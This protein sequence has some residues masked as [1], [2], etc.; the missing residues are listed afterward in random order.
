MKG[1]NG[2]IGDWI[3]GLSVLESAKFGARGALVRN[4][5]VTA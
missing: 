3:T 5:Q 4:L 1:A 2:V